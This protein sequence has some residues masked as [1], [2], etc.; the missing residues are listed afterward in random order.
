MKTYETPQIW[1]KLTDSK[2]VLTDSVQGGEVL[3]TYGM[4][5]LVIED[6]W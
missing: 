3:P 4:K 2:D 6:I 5:E 1:I